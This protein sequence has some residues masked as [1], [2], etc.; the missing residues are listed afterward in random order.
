LPVLK[1]GQFAGRTIEGK[2]GIHGNDIHSL[3][4]QYHQGVLAL[5]EAVG[6]LV[7]VLKETGQY[8][9]T[10]IIFTSDQGIAWGQKGFQVKLAPYDG[11]IRG[12]MIV[13]MPKKLPTGI[14]CNKAVGAPDLV[15][16]IFTAAGIDLP[17]KMHGRDLTPLL[18]NPERD[19][20]KSPLLMVHTGMS[21]GED[22]KT[23]PEDMSTDRIFSKQGIPWWVSLRTDRYKYIRNL[24]PGELEELYDMEEDPDELVNL[25]A[26]PN[27]KERLLT[28]R[29]GAIDELKRTDCP[30]AETMPPTASPL[31]RKNESQEN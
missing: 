25:A 28:L 20:W 24:L 2:S 27:Y 10:L 21:Y 3:V 5:D 22:C 12:P 11:T 8:E 16:T 18:E 15:P 6:K 19:D 30:F 31:K 7:E 14:V 1:S 29:K 13:S 4:R 9:N 23:V 26:D 17:W